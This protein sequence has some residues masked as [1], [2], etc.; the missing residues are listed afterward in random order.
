MTSGVAKEL[1]CYKKGPIP[2][3]LGG[4]I[5][6][7]KMRRADFIRAKCLCLV[8]VFIQKTKKYVKNY[9]SK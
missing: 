2:R 8:Q 9:T 4:V 3:F 7:E 5:K 6:G 1:E